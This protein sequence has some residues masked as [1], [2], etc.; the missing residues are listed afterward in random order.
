FYSLDYSYANYD[1][2]RA[3]IHRIGQ[4]NKC[5]YVHLIAKDT[6]DE[7]A[8]RTLKAKKSVAD[9]VVDGWRGYLS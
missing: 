7:K 8:L 9:E 6:V 1:Q 2:C 3:R 4:Q 5:T